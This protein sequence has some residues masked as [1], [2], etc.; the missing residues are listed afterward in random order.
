MRNVLSSIY[1]KVRQDH[2]WGEK[3]SEDLPAAVVNKIIDSGL[4]PRIVQKEL[5]AACGKAVLKQ[6][7]KCPAAQ[8]SY[9]LSPED[10]NPREIVKKTESIWMPIYAIAPVHQEPEETL[11]FWSIREVQFHDAEQA[12]HHLVG[13]LPRNGSGRVTSAIQLFDRE[14][15]C[16]T[17]RSGRL[18]YLEGRPGTHPDAEYVWGHWKA[19]NRIQDEIDVTRQYCQIH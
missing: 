19:S 16:V 1:N 14:R 9:A 13:Y 12:T 2:P 10:F 4:A 7:Q 5:I 6:A 8:S 3:F 18:Y 17:T 11:V 15:M